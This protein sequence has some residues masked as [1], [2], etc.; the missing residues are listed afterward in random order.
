ML[1][2]YLLGVTLPAYDF[3][4]D[5]PPQTPQF[6]YDPNSGYSQQDFNY[7]IDT[8]NKIYGNNGAE[9]YG[10]VDKYIDDTANMNQIYE[11]PYDLKYENQVNE[12]IQNQFQD[13]M[14]QRAM[15]EQQLQKKHQSQYYQI[16]NG[17]TLSQIARAHGVSVE[18][19]AK[20]NGIK[21]INMIKSGQLLRFDNGVNN[22]YK[23]TFRKRNVQNNTTQ[24]RK[25][26]KVSTKGNGTM[27]PEVVAT[28]TRPVKNKITNTERK[29]K[30]TNK[31]LPKKNITN[32]KNQTKQKPSSLSDVILNIGRRINAENQNKR[33]YDKFGN[34]IK[35]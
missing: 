26:T 10:G 33:L 34:Y 29:S 12:D 22:R 13:Y 7:A 11:S 25:H 18:K 1:N 30:P 28:V 35:K 32:K 21:D 23:S 16:K 15:Q 9:P 8:Y 4:M 2:P 31:I 17:D 5:V 14:Q 3:G 20:L 6:N 27:L 24:I 19:L